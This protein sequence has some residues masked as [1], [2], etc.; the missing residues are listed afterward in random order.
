VKAAIL[1]QPYLERVVCVDI[2]HIQ[3]PPASQAVSQASTSSTRVARG[4]SPKEQLLDRPAGSE[5]TMQAAVNPFGIGSA[6]AHAPTTATQLLLQPDAGRAAA[7]SDTL[8]AFAALLNAASA[9][10]TKLKP[11]PRTQALRALPPAAPGGLAPPTAAT[12]APTAPLLAIAPLLTPIST[13][14]TTIAAAAT[15]SGVKRGHATT[16]MPAAAGGGGAAGGPI[17]T[18]VTTTTTAGAATPMRRKRATSSAAAALS[19]RSPKR[20]AASSWPTRRQGGH[21]DDDDDYDDE[22]QGGTDDVIMEETASPSPDHHQLQQRRLSVDAPARGPKV[23]GGW[24][25]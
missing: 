24:G 1:T 25:L 17:A 14:L 23:G 7:A 21:D 20:A 18:T 4:S 3:R 10:E 22:E 19:S 6:G 13:T 11:L 9:A 5:T 2:N 8:S 12:F 15:S 16:T